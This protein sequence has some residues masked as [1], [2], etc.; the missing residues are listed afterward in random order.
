MGAG[1]LAKDFEDQTGAVDDLGLPA[2]FEIALLHR[3]HGAIDDDEVDRVVLNALA[4]MFD[5]AL[6]EQGR[7]AGSRDAGDFGASN[8][9]MDC[10]REPNGLLKP[11]FERTHGVA[12][13][14][15]GRGFRRGMHDEGAAARGAVWGKSSVGFVNNQSSSLS[16]PGSNNWI[17]VA[18]ITVEIACL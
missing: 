5:G 17:G 11:R 18:G 1:T 4:E 15:S 2:F 10:A 8:I 12:I 7:R 16:L 3:R 9:E 6:A 14:L 13:H